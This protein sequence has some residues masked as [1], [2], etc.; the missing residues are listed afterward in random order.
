MW[1]MNYCAITMGLLDFY[2][3]EFDHWMKWGGAGRIPPGRV[4]DKYEDRMMG[5]IMTILKGAAAAV[6]GEARHCLRHVVRTKTGSAFT[7]TRFTLDDY[8]P[9]MRA[10]IDSQPYKDY[11]NLHE[12]YGRQSIY[13]VVPDDVRE[14][15]NLM[16]DCAF[17]YGS[18]SKIMWGN[19][20]GGRKWNDCAT[21]TLELAT[22]LLRREPLPSLIIRADHLVDIIHN[23]GKIL[24]KFSCQFLQY[25]RHTDTPVG[26]W[27]FTRETQSHVVTMPALLACKSGN[28]DDEWM[29]GERPGTVN[30]LRQMSSAKC[31][32]GRS[33]KVCAQCISSKEYRDEKEKTKQEPRIWR[34]PGVDFPVL[35]E[36]LLVTAGL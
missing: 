31:A 23:G 26:D 17:L 15:A 4:Q 34:R 33:G 19:N 25:R 7:D 22:G 35:P 13:S 27:G 32:V 20:Y 36:E 8:P 12:G 11:D 14:I 9:S 16:R 28:L 1:V 2:L 6:A 10:V 21:G 30:D 24:N 5:N 29:E 18:E 3:T